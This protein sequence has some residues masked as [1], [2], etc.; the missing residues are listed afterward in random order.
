MI[1]DG[2][3]GGLDTK[4]PNAFIPLPPPPQA[5]VAA[6][7][8]VYSQI[9]IGLD[10]AGRIMLTTSPSSYWVGDHDID[11]FIA[12]LRAGAP[13]NGGQERQINPHTPPDVLPTPIDVLVERPC[14]VVIELDRARQWQFRTHDVGV[15]T[16]ADFGDDNCDLKHVNANGT[17]SG[18][19]PTADGCRIVYFRVQRRAADFERQG[20]NLHLELIQGFDALGKLLNSIE[21]IID[22]D[23]PNNGGQFLV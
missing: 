11:G 15:T 3:D 23:V 5:P 4:K 8:I 22:P 1:I 19:K 12:A 18:A 9:H 17:V 14:Y 20:I 21:I 10:G 2:F 16:K 7:E 13:P 6:A